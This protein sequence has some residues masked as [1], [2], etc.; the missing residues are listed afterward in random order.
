MRACSLYF[1]IPEIPKHRGEV[2]YIVD[3][4]WVN[5]LLRKLR[6]SFYYLNLSINQETPNS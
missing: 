5:T 4:L 1:L 3:F 2:T 6:D